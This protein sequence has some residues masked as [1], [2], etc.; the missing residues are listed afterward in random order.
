MITKYTSE[1]ALDFHTS[2]DEGRLHHA[3][4]QI[5]LQWPDQ[6]CT[7]SGQLKLLTRRLRLWPLNV[8][9]NANPPYNS[10]LIADAHGDLFDTTPVDG[11]NGLGTVFEIAKTTHGY[12]STPRPWSASMGPGGSPNPGKG[13]L[14]LGPTPRAT[15]SAKQA[16][17]CS[18]SSQPRTASQH[19]NDPGQL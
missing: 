16:A 8:N 17:R 2:K 12:A 11:A 6:S 19:P 1:A 9:F 7:K 13:S 14:I 4:L 3:E 10:S 18:K 5:L 15:C